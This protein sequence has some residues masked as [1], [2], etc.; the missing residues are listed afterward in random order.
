MPPLASIATCQGDASRTSRRLR[1]STWRV[2]PAPASAYQI[3]RSSFTE[4]RPEGEHDGPEPESARFLV[5]REQALVPARQV[6]Q[7][8]QIDL[9]E[10]LRNGARAPP[11]EPPDCAVGEDAPAQPAF[12]HH[13]GAVEMAQH[14]GG[15][16]GLRS[17][18]ARAVV[19][20]AASALAF[21]DGEAVL[22][23]P[24]FRQAAGV[25]L[26][27][28]IGEQEAVR[29]MGAAMRRKP[30]LPEACRPA[31]P[32]Q[33]RADQVGLGLRLVGSAVRREPIEEGAEVRP[34]AFERGIVMGLPILRFGNRVPG[35]K[36]CVVCLVLR[37]RLQYV[38][39]N[40]YQEV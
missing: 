27:R 39:G 9:K 14:L 4:F 37:N 1:A 29:H 17:V 23:A 11:V 21:N 15:G 34:E 20:R 5:E 24:L 8:G 26:G 10:L 18:R 36:S 30:L 12:R 40:K 28:L 25:V 6:Q 32:L 7:G 3:R 16:R 31:K 38:L 33:H 19:Q 2:L 35:S 22:V 13:I